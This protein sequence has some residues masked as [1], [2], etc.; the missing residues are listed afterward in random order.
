MDWIDINEQKPSDG[1]AVIVWVNKPSS[2][3]NIKTGIYYEWRSYCN[4]EL[5]AKGDD[6]QGLPSRDSKQVTHWRPL[7]IKKPK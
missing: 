3:P 4:G 6:F 7:K 5:T 2:P 1:Q